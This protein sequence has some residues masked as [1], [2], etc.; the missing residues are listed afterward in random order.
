MLSHYTECCGL[1]NKCHRPNTV[2]KITFNFHLPPVQV[3][4]DPSHQQKMNDVV[5]NQSFSSVQE[6]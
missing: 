3:Y 6:P 2:L 4:K 5:W 1:R